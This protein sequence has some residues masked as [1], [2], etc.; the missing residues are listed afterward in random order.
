MGETRVDLLH[1][2]EDL[3][4]AYP[5]T[6]EETVVTEIVANS[7]DSGAATIT[8]TADAA[9]RTLVI[10]DDGRGMRRRELARYHDVAASTK[11]RGDTIGFAGVGIKIALLISEQ[12][13]TET[14]SGRHHVAT[15]WGLTSRHRA[16]WKWTPPPG[17]VVERG[18]AVRLTLDNGLSPLLDPGYLETLLRRDFEPL[19]APALTT[20]LAVRYPRGV[21]F[22]VNG[23]RLAPETGD[24]DDTAELGVRLGRQRKPSALG[25]LSRASTPLAADRVGV[26][27][28]TLGKVIKRGWEW[29]SLTPVGADRL[30]G[31]IEVPALAHC[32]TLNKADFM[33]GGPHAGVYLAY[34]KAIQEAVSHQ[35]GVWGD[36]T[37]AAEHTRRRVARPVERDLERVLTDS[38]PGFPCS[39]RWSRVVAAG[40]GAS[41]DPEAGRAVC[42]VASRLAQAHRGHCRLRAVVPQRH[43]PR[44]RQRVTRPRSHRHARTR[45]PRR[46]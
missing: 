37:E 36:G 6:P 23:H 13:V 42:R 35:L 39:L 14:R 4:D 27:V 30:T 11:V 31:L 43:R 32:L 17:H 24:T 5:A 22:T 10:V 25:W 12:V 2:L 26:A 40:K 46:R 44:P 34:R 38:P 29:L 20:F 28:S 8:L 21:R 45:S 41:R 33:R 7:L 18:T 1:L 15:T 16:P 3:R 19:L 9:A